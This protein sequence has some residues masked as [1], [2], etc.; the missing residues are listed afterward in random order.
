MT[1]IKDQ[2]AE[3]KT[4]GYQ[5][6]FG[7]VFEHAFENYKKI[8]LYA[9]LLFFVFTILLYILITAGFISYIGIKNMEEFLNNLKSF[10]T[11]KTIPTNILLPLKA[12]LILFSSLLSPFIAGFY[13]MADCG[14]K[15]NEFHV[16]TMFNY[17]KAPYFWNIFSAT[18]LI[19][20]LSTG[21]SILL[22]LSGFEI[23]GLL[24]SLTISFLT[25]LTIPLIIFG[26]LNAIDAIKSSII[27]ISKQP[28]ILLGL[29]IVAIIAALIGLFGLCIGIFFTYPFM[30]S[31]TYAIYSSIIGI[32]SEVELEQVDFEI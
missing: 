1:P 20:L 25:F 15:G 30:F 27:I 5:L 19:S 22:E 28:I 26:D 14:E 13:N 18:L 17:Y 9:G 29:V 2:I 21:L 10:Q 31:M 3:I 23:T 4:N 24:I 11:Q 16:S 32:N 7:T 8:A 6:D 12:G